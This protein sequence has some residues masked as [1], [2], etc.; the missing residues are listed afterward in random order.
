MAKERTKFS[1][2]KGINAFL[3]S[4]ILSIGIS[5]LLVYISEKI[6]G[7]G[8]W[9]A[10]I[11]LTYWMYKS[12]YIKRIWGRTFAGLAIESFAMPLVIFVFVFYVFY[13]NVFTWRIFALGKQ[14]VWPIY[15]LT[16]FRARLGFAKVFIVLDDYRNWCW[17]MLFRSSLL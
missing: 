3:S 15:F 14:Y 7:W 1:F 10:L 6:A 13:L 16:K 17:F 4:L 12:D 8:F 11:G 2:K 9:I 5:I